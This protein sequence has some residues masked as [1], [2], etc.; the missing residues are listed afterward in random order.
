MK[1]FLEQ[2]FKGIFK[3]KTLEEKITPHLKFRENGDVD[4]DPKSRHPTFVEYNNVRLQIQSAKNSGQKEIMT[5]LSIACWDEIAHDRY[6][7]SVVRENKD[8]YRHLIKW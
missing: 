4:Y 8:G 2:L 3:V 6:S 7:I 1:K 5:N